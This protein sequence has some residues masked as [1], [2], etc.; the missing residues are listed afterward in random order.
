VFH[1]TGQFLKAARHAAFKSART[2]SPAAAD[3]SAAGR[4]PA[5]EL[6]LHS[7]PAH[8]IKATE[9]PRQNQQRWFLHEP[10]SQENGS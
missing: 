1:K 4:E 9:T 7:I 5:G 8:L 3:I 6:Y 2:P 10:G